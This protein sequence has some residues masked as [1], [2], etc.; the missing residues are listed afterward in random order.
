MGSSARP[1]RKRA[2]PDVYT[3]IGLNTDTMMVGNIGSAQLLD[4]TAI[5]DGMNLA[6]RLETANKDF[7]TLIL[8]G[9]GTFEAVKD[10]VEAREV[11]R[12]RVA[13]KKQA[14]AIYEL[15]S[16]KGKLGGEK[17]KVIDLYARALVMYRARGFAEATVALDEA[18]ALDSSDGPSLR[19]Q[20][21]C[22]ALAQQAPE[23][24]WEAV[25]ELS[26]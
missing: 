2:C 11:D 25:S 22:R 21:R 23:A 15:L 24:G 14:V 17:K 3:R 18:L 4:Y 7:G 13:G 5:G 12:V 8:I 9:P 20:A 19:L 16:L 26:K 1:S 6:A 10:A